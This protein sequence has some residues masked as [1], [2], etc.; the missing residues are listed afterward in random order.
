MIRAFHAHLAVLNRRRIVPLT[1]ATAAL[2]MLGVVANLVV[3]GTVE[4]TNVGGLLLSGLVLALVRWSSRPGLPAIV[5]GYVALAWG[6]V[7][8]SAYLAEVE[9]GHA[10]HAASHLA[11]FFVTRYVAS[12]SVLWRPRDLAL[13][14]VLGHLLV[15]PVLR[16]ASPPDAYL[17][18]PIWTATAWLA[19]YLIYRAQREAFAARY[20][21][22][23]QRDELASAN[24]HL[25]RLNTEKND[26][27]AI[28]AHDLR[29]PLMGMSAVLRLAADDAARVW[30]AGVSTLQAL[31]QSCRDMADL[32]TRV[33]DAH[34]AEDQLGP[35]VIER[36]DIRPVLSEVV[37]AHQPRA[38][39]K[40][41]S[42]SID[43]PDE[44]CVARVDAQAL[45]RVLD[46]L[47]SNALKFTPPGGDVH[48]AM[49]SAG[50]SI[51]IVVADSGP[52]IAECD[53]PRLFSKF[54]RLRPRPTDGEGS[55]GLGLYIVKRLVEAM[56]GTV[57]VESSSD[58]G[59]TFVVSLADG[60]C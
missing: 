5:Y 23:R 57:V 48:V 35:V 2:L 6:S 37:G 42:L 40:G 8:V 36:R 51:A 46:N 29:S 55:S 58:R 7:E 44:P 49:R 10:T 19:A 22:E 28:A 34:S 33:L 25:E 26:L 31:D 17:Y 20:R 11:L 32:V 24:R 15:L 52:G 3:T 39:E 56:G 1:L 54:G 14:L 30:S 12:I 38:G 60:P 27:M 16:V 21:L 18:V 13:A 47:L 53:R 9:L 50:G 59:A 41:I 4:R 45:G 43:A